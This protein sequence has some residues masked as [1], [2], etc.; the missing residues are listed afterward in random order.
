[1]KIVAIIQARMTS[2]R[3]PRKVL[4]PLAGVPVLKQVYNRTCLIQGVDEVLVVTPASIANNALAHWCVCN[5][6][7]VF[8]AHGS[9]LDVLDYFIQAGRMLQADVVVRITADC[10]FLDPVVSTKILERFLC[11]PLCDYATNVSPPS[12]PDG[13]DT[14]I[15]RFSVLEQVWTKVNEPMA[16]EHVTWYIRQ[17][18]EL[19]KIENM[20]HYTDLSALRWTLDTQEDYLVLSRI[21]EELNKRNQF[22][23]LNEILTL[24][25]EHPEIKC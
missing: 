4:L 25:Q 22:G 10:P 19:F 2:T 12:Y 6:I 3:L 1:M 11:T 16:R 17:H 21:A 13:L 20:V 15:V 18:P 7:P 23:Y 14:E 9:E 5:R 8:R 24:L